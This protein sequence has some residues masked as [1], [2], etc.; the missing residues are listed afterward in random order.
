VN[1]L[2]IFFKWIKSAEPNQD[3]SIKLFENGAGHL[4]V[5]LQRSIRGSSGGLLFASVAEAICYIEHGK[6]EDEYRWRDV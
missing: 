4:G 2:E 1:V 3:R 5:Q 6:E